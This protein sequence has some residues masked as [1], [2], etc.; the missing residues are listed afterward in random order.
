MITPQKGGPPQMTK[1]EWETC[2]SPHRMLVFL[3]GAISE[4]ISKDFPRLCSTEGDI[5]GGDGQFITDEECRLFILG[6]VNRLQAFPLDEAS[7]VALEAYRQY[8]L[9][10]TSSDPFFD[11]C[12]KI[13]EQLL[14]GRGAAISHMAAMWSEDPAGAGHAALDIACAVANIVARESVA[15]TCADATDDDWFSWSWG[16]GPP[17]PLW[18]STRFAEEQA[19]ASLLRE[20]VQYPPIACD[21]RPL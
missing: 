2:Q 15:V 8:A 1:T 3:R 18:Q 11:A 17:D 9:G 21:G 19:Q 16:S 5:Y 14:A 7:T 20:I 12:R 13:H 4:E 6:C 10:N